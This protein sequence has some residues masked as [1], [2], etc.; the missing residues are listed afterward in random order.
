MAPP[1]RP[2][3]CITSP[4][5]GAA[6]ST[7]G[8]QCRAGPRNHGAPKRVGDTRQG[9]VDHHH[10][11]ASL[12]TYRVSQRPVSK[13]DKWWPS[14]ADWPRGSHWQLICAGC[15]AASRRGVNSRERE[16]GY[17]WLLRRLLGSQGKHAHERGDFY[18]FAWRR[19]V[20]CGQ[21]TKIGTCAP[22]PS[23]FS[24][25]RLT[26]LRR[27]IAVS[28]GPTCSCRPSG[29]CRSGP[30]VGPGGRVACGMCA[31]R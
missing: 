23:P 8:I 30:V 9:I 27:S 3:G 28:R 12:A 24:R 21:D 1:S 11:A 20:K 18:W 17:P 16:A 19:G 25:P 10:V 26:V 31:H 4:G 15:A 22:F 2:A 29:P 14:S 7:C 6:L 5:Y 13:H